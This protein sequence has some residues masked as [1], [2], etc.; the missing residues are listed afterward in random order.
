MC[1]YYIASFLEFLF[2][3][4]FQRIPKDLYSAFLFFRIAS[5]GSN[6]HLFPKNFPRYPLFA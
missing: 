2:I 1:I 4:P 3:Y 5:A 6:R